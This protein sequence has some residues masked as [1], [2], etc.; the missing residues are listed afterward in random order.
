M[1]SG[2]SANYYLLPQPD[3]PE[4]KIA[5]PVK[6]QKQM[7]IP[8]GKSKHQTAA[9]KDIHQAI[10]VKQP[11]ELCIN[12]NGN[13]W[14]QYYEKRAESDYV[15]IKLYHPPR[16][17]GFDIENISKVHVEG[18]GMLSKLA[19]TLQKLEKLQFRKCTNIF[20]D[21][22]KNKSRED[23]VVANLREV[24]EKNNIGIVVYTKKECDVTEEE[25]GYVTGA[26]KALGLS[27]ECVTMKYGKDF[28]W[29]CSGQFG[30]YWAIQEEKDL[31][32][33][34]QEI[35]HDQHKVRDF[36]NHVQTMLDNV[37]TEVCSYH[38]FQMG[39]T[40]KKIIAAAACLTFPPFVG[41]DY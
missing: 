24:I 12:I 41:L 3:G 19:G 38:R 17:Q 16:G 20:L 21:A 14:Y 5:A 1:G 35:K 13:Y 36:R 32:Q 22:A 10:N 2:K 6:F 9:Q 4:Q 31:E 15:D 39:K 11:V 18:M 33:E 25:K 7:E 29:T 34:L 23:I 28:S 8:K 30:W 40:Y 27:D 37:E 26:T